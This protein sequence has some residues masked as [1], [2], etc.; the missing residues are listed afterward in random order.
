MMHTKGWKRLFQEYVN[1]SDGCCVSLD[2]EED[3]S[4]Q[5]GIEKDI[6]QPFTPRPQEEPPRR[7]PLR[8]R[9][10]RL[11]GIAGTRKRDRSCWTQP[12]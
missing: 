11:P 8:P 4:S 5:G 7:T 12:Q 3:E 10:Q 6:R 9:R 1:H 2:T